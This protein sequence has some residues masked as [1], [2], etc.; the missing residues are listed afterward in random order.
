M[1][2]QT[3]KWK[4]AL[5]E[6]ESYDATYLP[7]I[8][9]VFFFWKT[10]ALL[11]KT[12]ETKNPPLPEKF[13]ARLCCFVCGLAYKKPGP[14]PDAFRLDKTGL[15]EAAVELKAT[16]TPSGFT[17]VKRDLNFDELYWVSFAGYKDLRFE[18]YRFD[19][20]QIRRFVDKSKTNRDRAT[21]T[22]AKVAEHF[23]LRPIRRAR[24][25]IVSAD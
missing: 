17:D 2:T 9:E 20:E 16:I 25:G 6:C 12:T 3:V 21:M 22:L 1:S 14:G 23:D 11:A 4:G 8:L 24:I 19:K 18:I 13:S 15:V 10:A 5:Y 7:S